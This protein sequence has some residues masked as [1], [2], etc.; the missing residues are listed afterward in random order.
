MV[1]PVQHV[2]VVLTL[3]FGSKRMQ[4]V[5]ECLIPLRIIGTMCDKIKEITASMKTF[6]DDYID[7]DN[8]SG[9]SESNEGFEDDGGDDNYDYDN[10]SDDDD[11]DD[12]Y[13]DDGGGDCDDV[14]G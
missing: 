4:A 6:V 10:A 5:S 12:D 8:E 13:D 7:D 2:T 9:D 14:H 1:E 3:L 11:N